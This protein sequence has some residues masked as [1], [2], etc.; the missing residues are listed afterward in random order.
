MNRIATPAALALVLAVSG[1]ARAQDLVLPPPAPADLAVTGAL[2]DAAPP[3]DADREPV[4]VAWPLAAG[5]PLRT[6]TA[7]FVA[8]SREHWF[9]VTAAELEAGVD[10]AIASRGALVRLSPLARERGAAPPSPPSLAD[11]V[12]VDGAGESHRG[13]AAVAALADDEALA[14][15][16]ARLPEGS[17]ALRLRPELGAGPFR[18]RLEG[19]ATSGAVG[20]LVHVFEPGSEVV[21]T[22]GADRSA[23]AADSTGEITLALEDAGRRLAPV[24]IVGFVHSPGGAVTPLDFV[25]GPE[26]RLHARFPTRGED[27]R[28]G[29]WQAEVAVVAAAAPAAIDGGGDE[30]ALRR[31]RP[32]GS[33]MLHRRTA[34]T[35]FAVALP[36]ARLVGAVEL[37]GPPTATGL[38]VAVPVEV[39][40]AGR[41][42]VRGTLAAKRAGGARF[43][44]ARAESAAWLEPGTGALAL[45]FPAA[46][47]AAAAPGTELE[48]V[49]LE[50]VDPGRLGLLERRALMLPLGVR[51]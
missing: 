32:R 51:P 48:L 6:A 39:A 28:A 3:V 22:L 49:E 4:A 31:Q 42:A 44:V 35:A 43:A 17:A 7:P 14:A 11:V 26:G 33:P 38:A 2:A 8:A 16:G 27:A 21:L 5:S 30:P 46:V 25:P 18:L 34:R 9:R 15:A 50:L 40:S 13:A 41:Y 45:E 36:T 23:Y 1:A 29:L 37:V 12:I 24:E 10:P 47:L 19:A 20:Y